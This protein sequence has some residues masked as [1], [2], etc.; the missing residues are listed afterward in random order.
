MM[1]KV[2]ITTVPALWR[3]EASLGYIV[4]FRLARAML[5]KKPKK[6]EMSK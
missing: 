1:G 6:S 2:V 3:I 4:N 5:K